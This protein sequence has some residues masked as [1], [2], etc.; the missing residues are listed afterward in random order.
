MPQD[1]KPPDPVDVSKRYDV[2]CN[3]YG[4]QTVVYRNVLFKGAKSLFSTGSFDV[5]SQFLELEQVNG[6]TIFISRAGI[7][8]FVSTAK[9]PEASWLH[10]R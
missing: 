1:A 6:D 10:E 3:R 7:T 8:A 4:P 2:Y 5:L 9:V